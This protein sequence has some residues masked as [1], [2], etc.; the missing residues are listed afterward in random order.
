MSKKPLGPG[1]LE[2][3]V[4]ETFQRSG[5]DDIGPNTPAALFVTV[6]KWDGLLNEVELRG[7]RMLIRELTPMQ[8]QF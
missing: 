6:S 3:V 2:E 8:V 1:K 5:I 7:L 4:R